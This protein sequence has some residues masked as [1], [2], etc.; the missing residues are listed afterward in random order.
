MKKEWL[1]ADVTAV[2]SLYRAKRAI[3]GV[4]VAGR[5]F[6]PIPVV[7]VVEESLCCVGTPS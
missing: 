3:F 4:I 2:R 1:V 6:W 5:V 7:F